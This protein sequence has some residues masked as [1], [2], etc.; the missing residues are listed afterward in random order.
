MVL[1]LINVQA[2]QDPKAKSVLDALSN[3]TKSYSSIRAQ[4]T[5]GLEN[6]RDNVKE[7]FSGSIVMKGDKYKLSAM[8]TET[9]FDGKTIWTYLPEVK[10]VYISSPEENDYSILGD[11]S[12]LFTIYQ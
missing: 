6:S 8:G 3:K 4:F 1:L 12:R 5:I 9:F 2:Q 7:E 11:P 10:E